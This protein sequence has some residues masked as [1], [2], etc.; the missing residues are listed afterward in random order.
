MEEKIRGI[1]R[2]NSEVSMWEWESNGEGEV[3]EA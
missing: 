1:R 3:N 2:V